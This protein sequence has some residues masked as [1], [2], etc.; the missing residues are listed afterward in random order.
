MQYNFSNFK[1]E[2]SKIVDYLSKEY[3]QL[4]IGRASPMILDSVSVESYGS[5]VS[6]KNIASVSIEDPKTLRIIPWD[7]NQIKGIE[8]GIVSSNLGLSV[9]VD[10]EGIRVIFPQLTTETR[11]TLVKVLKEKLEESRITVRK[12]R[13]QVWDK[14]QKLEKEGNLTEDERFKA[15]ED[16]QKV[17]DEINQKLENVFEKKEKEVMG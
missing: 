1:L 7:K 8:K 5:Y 13:E 9:A 11:Q 14:I 4:N 12:E 16:L 6:L 10:G 15:K 17:I 2:I 3:G